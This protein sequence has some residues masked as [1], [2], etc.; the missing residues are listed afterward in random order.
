M[1][2][3][4]SNASLLARRDFLRLGSFA[5]IGLAGGTWPFLAYGADSTSLLSVGYVDAEPEEGT[6]LWL[7]PAERLLAGDPAF[8]ARD[9]R[10][11]ILSSSRTAQKRRYKGT[12]I[13][14]VYPVHGYQPKA[15]PI[16]RAWSCRDNESGP[17]VSAPVAFGVPIVADCGLRL[18]LTHFK[19]GENAD[20][21]DGTPIA[22]DDSVQLSTGSASGD[23]KLRRGVYVVACREQSGRS[24]PNWSSIAITR[25]DGAVVV[26]HRERSSHLILRI[27]Y[28][29]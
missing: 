13:D 29:S 27:D 19:P 24:N 1:S 3:K 10:V 8:L 22:S 2:D 7:K 17:T 25:R 14:V 18:L 16:Y 9:A 21:V 20:V 4:S 5:V 6:L 15:Y 28:A 11:T 26:A 12:A 23:P